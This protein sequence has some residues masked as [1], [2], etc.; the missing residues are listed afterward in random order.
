MSDFVNA[1]CEWY[2]TW[3]CIN[4]YDRWK[5]NIYIYLLHVEL[6]NYGE[7]WKVK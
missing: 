1:Y 7:L 4:R 2:H 3:K 6:N 5:K